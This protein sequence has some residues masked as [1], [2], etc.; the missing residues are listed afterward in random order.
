[1]ADYARIYREHPERYDELVRAEDHEQRL[2]S[3]LESVCIIAGASV[4]EAGAGTGRLTR[5]LLDAGADHIVATEVEPAM[6]DVARRRLADVERRVRYE[7]AD[8]RALPV[9]TTC[10]DV[11][12]A[13]W[14]FGHLR[15]WHA[16]DWRAQ[17]G[18]AIGE[19]NRVTRP[20][21]TVVII[22]TLGTGQSEPAAP[23]EDLADYYRWLETDHGFKRSA[24]RTDY[25]FATVEEAA[26]VTGFFFGEAFAARVRD[27]AWSTVP[28]CTG[29]WSRPSRSTAHDGAER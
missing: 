16:G 15:H 25:S 14:V 17:I 28:E 29:I 27:E 6:L 7:V 8:A 21:G 18:A 12:I 22:E 19:L 23:N 13:G 9:A 5:I 26:R 2:R 24:V 20:G 11:G 1:M 3:A 4:V 10:A